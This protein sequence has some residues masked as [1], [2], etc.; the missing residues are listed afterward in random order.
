MSP[1]SIFLYP[2]L[3]KILKL[4]LKRHTVN[5]RIFSFLINQKQIHQAKELSITSIM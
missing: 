2:Q 3:I 1:I 4:K 5:V